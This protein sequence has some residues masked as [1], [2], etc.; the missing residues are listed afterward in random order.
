MLLSVLV[1][2]LGDIVT[3]EFNDP[4]LALD[5]CQLNNP[6]LVLVDYM[7][8]N[9]DGIQ[10]I[11][12]FRTLSSKANIPVLMITADSDIEVRHK[13]LEATANDFLNKP[14]DS[15]ELSAR[16]KNMLAL[17][18]AQLQLS[19]KAAWLG[20]E[21]KKAT[22]QILKTERE[23]IFRLARAAEYKDPETG[24]HIK[25]MSLYA[26][27]IAKNLGLSED[28]Q[29][30]IIDAAP[31]HDIGKIGI[32]DNVL[33]KP[34]VLDAEERKVIFQHPWFGKQ[35]LAGSSSKL[36]QAAEVI[37]FSHHEKFDGSGYP[38]GL[39]GS[40]IPLYGRI[41]ALADVFDALTSARPYKE[42]WTIE[43]TISFIKEQSSV[44]FD[45]ACVDAFFKNWENVLEIK[46]KHEDEN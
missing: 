5:W 14:I 42:A 25:R 29:Q 12:A 3:Y 33:L 38:Q 46:E 28:E 24:A 6:D 41:V 2:R 11:K 8:P 39:A 45:P 35:M 20:D 19:N 18:K 37:A 40:D 43:K 17:R 1:K 31:M 9:L 22:A 34:G 27:H 10:F 23:V 32:P 21:V 7:M 30:L 15:V 44:H 4:M 36:L 16:V 26:G 13:A